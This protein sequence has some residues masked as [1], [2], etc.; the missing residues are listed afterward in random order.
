MAHHC[1][2][3]FCMARKKLRKHP[4]YYKRQ[5]KC[6]NC[7]ERDWRRDDYRHAVELPQIR[8]KTDRY[9]VCHSACYAYPHRIGSVGC[10]FELDGAYRDIPGLDIDGRYLT[11]P[12]QIPADREQ[13]QEGSTDGQDRA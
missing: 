4:N 6:H 12:H 7:G 11:H 1:R 5:P 8:G 9:R 2:C 10:M 3:K 13:A